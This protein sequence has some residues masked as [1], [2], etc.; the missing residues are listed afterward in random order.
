MALAFIVDDDES[1]VGN[2]GLSDAADA[3]PV[4][5][6]VRRRGTDDEVVCP[7]ID[8]DGAVDNTG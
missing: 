3:T 8:D 6:T 1:D 4:L 2:S 7:V 5:V